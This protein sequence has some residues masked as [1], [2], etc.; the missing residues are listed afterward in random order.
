MSTENDIL[1]EFNLEDFSWD[2]EAI[3]S[4]EDVVTELPKD[5]EESE[6]EKPIETPVVDTPVIVTGLDETGK[7]KE[8]ASKEGDSEQEGSETKE[9]DTPPGIGTRKEDFLRLREQG[10]LDFEDEE[11]SAE[12]FDPEEFLKTKQEE[13]L[14]KR[15]ESLLSQIPPGLKDMIKYSAKG[16]DFMEIVRDLA[17]PTELDKT[18]D[19]TSSEN[20]K[21]VI[22]HALKS[23]GRSSEEIKEYIEFLEFKGKLETEAKSR[24]DKFLV[25]EETREEKRLQEHR[26]RI[27]KQNQKIKQDLKEAQEILKNK[28]ETFNGVRFTK[29][30]KKELPDFIY[31]PTV[32]LEDGRVTTE[33]NYQLLQALQDKEKTLFLAKI[34]KADF[35]LDDLKKDLENKVI[36][37]VENSLQGRNS[38]QGSS[39][40]QTPRSHLVDFL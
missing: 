5:Q 17:V 36:T 7:T 12:D 11:I 39:Q 1:S 9:D 35:K 16:G 40:I 28:T 37:K 33:F 38:G 20:Q 34:I 25:E 27:A 26:E 15:L 19:I 2:T 8:E 30:E 6:E 18:L 32:E 29:T 22:M 10:F 3:V 13:T 31:S 21:Q 23:E 4:K 24:F 14:D